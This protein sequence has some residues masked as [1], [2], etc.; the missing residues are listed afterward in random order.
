MRPIFAVLALA[1]CAV[2]ARPGLA[3]SCVAEPGAICVGDEAVGYDELIL[4]LRSADVAILGERHDNPLHHDWQARITGDLAPGGLAFE[5]VPA[6]REDYANAARLDGDDLAEALEWA[7]SG[8]PDFAMY[9]PIFDAAPEAWVAG[10]GVAS[11]ALRMAVKEGAAKA[12]PEGAE[13]YGLSERLDQATIDAMLKEQDLAHCG[14]LPTAMLPG[15]VEAQQLRDA[16][17]A[18]AALR[19]LDAGHAPVVL[20]TGNGHAR[21]DRGAPLYLGRA[22]PSAK[23][24]SVGLVELDGAPASDPASAPV[25]FDAVIFTAAHDRSDPCEDFIRKRRKP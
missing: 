12:W 6:A 16:A 21:A 7:E 15:M 5:M 20:I 13:R 25:P 2:F 9:R 10:G 1:L 22:A 17:F 11:E 3:A 4:R 18:D 19:L 24:M 8:W 14:A 23:V